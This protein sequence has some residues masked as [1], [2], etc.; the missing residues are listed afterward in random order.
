MT[1]DPLTSPAVF[2]A[3]DRHVFLVLGMGTNP[4]VGWS[5][6][7]G[8]ACDEAHEAG[9]LVIAAPILADHTWAATAPVP[10]PRRRPLPQISDEPASSPGTPSG[11]GS[12]VGGFSVGGRPVVDGAGWVFQ[13][14]DP[15][16]IDWPTDDPPASVVV[17]AY[18]ARGVM[19]P[20]AAIEAMWATA[21]HLDPEVLARVRDGLRADDTPTEQLDRALFLPAV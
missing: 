7:F 3:P 10:E 19:V 15:E 5:R 1:T 21:D 4:V 13:R 17:A 16:P 6:D 12:D 14:E 20:E 18:A 11:S 8:H 2:L 9:G